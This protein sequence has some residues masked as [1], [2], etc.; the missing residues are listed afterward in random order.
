MTEALTT[1][2][3]HRPALSR[4]MAGVLAAGI[5]VG[6]LGS[7]LST[8]AFDT[9]SSAPTAARTSVS[10]EAGNSLGQVAQA[11]GAQDL[12]REG[13]TGAGVGVA[14]IDTGVAQAEGLAGADVVHGPDFSGTDRDGDGIGHGTH[15]AGIIVGSGDTGGIAPG[16]TL[17]SVKAAADDGETDPMD[18]ANAINWVVDHRGEHGIRVLNLAFAADA[19][20]E[21]TDPLIEA[22]DRAVRAGIVVVTAA[23]NDGQQ[24]TSLG[25]PATSRLAL[26]VGAS[27]MRGTAAV[28][29]DVVAEYSSVGSNERHPDLVAPGTSIASVRAPG[30]DAE[31]KHPKAHVGEDGIKGTGTSQSAAVVSG[32]VALLLERNPELGPREVKRVLT[33]AA[34]SFDDVSP[35][36]QG[37]GALDLDGSVDAL[38]TGEW[39]R[40][41]WRRFSWRDAGWERFSWRDAGWE[42]FSW[43]DAG[44]ERFSW[45]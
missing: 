21:G 25:S 16:A 18:V 15:L 4:R 6:S 3:S 13:L 40:F 19:I 24:A 39:Q 30:S 29:D 12:Y 2:D 37:A 26:T 32:A 22:V 9:R 5:M 36:V 42:R 45:R 1:T 33:G 8:D 38:E 11:I 27:D 34:D 44:W 23:G 14:L 7:A 35:A 10:V 28:G 17:L 31:V 41:S 43:R 20:G